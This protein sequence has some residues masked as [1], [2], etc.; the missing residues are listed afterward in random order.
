MRRQAGRRA[1][2]GRF[3][4]SGVELAGTPG[5]DGDLELLRLA[6]ESAKA[7]G[8][9]RFAIDVGDAGIV[10]SLLMD[11]PK[12]S[13]ADDLG[14][15]RSQ[16][17][18]GAGAR[19]RGPCRSDGHRAGRPRKAARGEGSP[20]RGAATHRGNSSSRSGRA[21]AGRLRRRRWAGSRRCP[22][23]RPRGGA[24]P[25]LLY[26]DDLP[27]LCSRHGRRH[28]LGRPIRRAPRALRVGS[29]CGRVCPRPR[30]DGGGLAGCRD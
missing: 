20:G 19:L 30:P 15:S 26:G 6:V 12:G 25:R 18:R 7:A 23:R 1:S 28:R 21:S 2:T 17:R 29:A 22:Q 3:H 4:R 27:C 5:L 16:G 8:L 13:S 10:R 14:R 11:L 9:D 24:W